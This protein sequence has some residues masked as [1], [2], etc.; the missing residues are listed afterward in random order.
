MPPSPIEAHIKN[1]KRVLF[2]DNEA[3]IPGPADTHKDIVAEARQAKFYSQPMPKGSV[4]N[5]A[6]ISGKSAHLPPRTSNSPL[7][8]PRIDKLRDK[9]FDSFKTWSGKL[10]RQISNLRGK[11]GD[12]DQDPQ[13]T[14]Q[15]PSAMDSVPVDR[16]FDALQGPELDS[17]RV[18]V[19]RS[20]IGHRLVLLMRI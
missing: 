2:R 17:L 14:T 1:G 9:R 18:H 5:E 13:T 19:F 4:L 15:Q 6:I 11:S 10:E 3:F 12:S 20:T 16:Y 7:K 8:N